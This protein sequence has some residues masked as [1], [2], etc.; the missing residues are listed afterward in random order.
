M[1]YRALGGTG[2]K[3]S[4]L[5]LG[6]I[7]LQRLSRAEAKSLLA[8]AAD[9]GINLI[10]TARGYSVSEEL[11]G[12][13][14]T[15]RR[16]DWFVA[17]KSMARSKSAIIDDIQTSLKNLKTDYIDL[18]QIHNVRTDSEWQQVLADDGALAGVLAAVETGLV[19]YAGIT[20]HSADMMAAAL[21]SDHFSTMM[22][23][24]NIVEEDKQSIFES[25]HARGV[26]TLAMK[27][28]AGG[29][30][31][32]PQKALRYLA[33]DNIVD[34]LLVGMDSPAQVSENVAALAAGPLT[35]D[36]ECELR[37]MALDLGQDFCRRCGYCQP[38]P[39]GIDISTVFLLETYYDRYEL[40]DWARDRYAGLPVLATLCAG[41]G[42]CLD[43]CP[44]GLQIPDRL[45]RAAGKLGVKKSMS[46]RTEA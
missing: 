23:A 33:A 8:A 2:F 4:R 30:I 3:I 7:P 34:C 20:S 29:V 6:G 38:C 45:A 40:K 25:A 16:R 17:S 42:E 9:A 27:P 18:Y 46:S 36:E 44:Y 14:L 22:L 15:G 5:G 28:L 26:G 35:E 12:Y 1:E 32:D 11:I 31:P 43:K 37:E 19:R 39:E 21:E 13:G 41:C 24:Y 10:D